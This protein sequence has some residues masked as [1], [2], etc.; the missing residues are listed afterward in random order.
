VEGERD[1]ATN[2][3]VT[4]EFRAIWSQGQ[5][6]AF[7]GPDRASGAWSEL[8]ALVEPHYTKAGNGRQK[9]A[10]SAIERVCLAIMLRIYFLQPWF[11]LSDPS[12]EEAFYD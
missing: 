2:T 7:S 1:A 4:G 6:G 5:A 8:L 11:N 9:P 10:L 3:G 12:M